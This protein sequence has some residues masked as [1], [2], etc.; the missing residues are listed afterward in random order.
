MPAMGGGTR[1]LLAGG[2]VILLSGVTAAGAGP[3]VPVAQPSLVPLGGA[4]PSDY[5]PGE[6][7]VRFRGGSTSTERAAALR[8]RGARSTDRLG[9]PGLV[10]V[11]LERGASVED[12]A[13]ALEADPDVLYA[14]PNYLNRIS[15]LPDDP[16][17]GRLWGL[18]QPL[19]PDIDAPS[20]WNQTTG[21]SAAV[22]AVIDSGVA[23]GHPDLR[24]NIWMNP[25]ETPGNGVDD[26]GNGFVDDVRG[27]DFV[28]NDATPLDFNG[29]GTHVAGTIGAEGN[30]GIGVTGVNWDVSIM[31]VRAADTFGRLPNSKVVQAIDYACDNGARVVNGSFGSGSFAA[32][33]ASVVTSAACADTL[34]VF[35]AGNSGSDL[36]GTGG[37]QDTYPCE[38]HRPSTG[39]GVNADN[40]L[41]VG[42]SNRT[43]G[44]AG[45]SNRG[46]LAVQLAAPGVSILSTFP[47]FVSVPGSQ[48]G[49]EGRKAAFRDR[50]G[51]R[52]G[53]PP[54][55]RTRA[56]EK[57]G[58]HSLADSP[59][60]RYP[61]N[62]NTS[63]RQLQP[64]SLSGRVGC[65]LEYDMWLESQRHDGVLIDL[66]AGPPIF[67]NL[68]SWA[69]S[70]G[71]RFLP[72]FEDLSDYDG[73]RRVS[74]RF[75]FLSDASGRRDGVYLDNLLVTCLVG[76]ASR[77]RSVSGTSMAAPHVA[78]VA[79]LLL[80]DD[81]ARTVADLEAA[82]LGGVDPVPG[83]AG[84]VETGG[85]LNAARALGVVPD[86]AAPDTTITTGPTGS[87]SLRTATFEFVADEPD[88]TFQCRLGGGSWTTCATPKTYGGLASG[89]H[90]FRVRAMDGNGNGNADPS[91]ATRMW[92][93]T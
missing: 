41:C 78:G 70:T 7:I 69:G 13:A 61:T 54:W 55:D 19:G 23:Y 33:I 2:I 59:R 82:I 22:V 76:N 36:D 42:A 21:S 67:A 73:A 17:L 24:D 25:G 34:F 29:H 88:A 86:Q 39:G 92:R 77:Y 80:A 31:P 74:L 52:T 16:L 89:Q 57:S 18:S 64:F 15:L 6:L 47:R 37:G 87:T 68:T 48:E 51:R 26:D 53:S 35:A 83:M 3:R 72:L 81:P 8:A 10:R 14:E 49:F 66:A 60:G 62:A 32:A 85:R 27:W 20:A 45:F 56:K 38:L 46:A 71:G 93:V 11:E 43:D 44:L 65:G 4:E 90:V 40:V 30:N 28:Q 91:P 5:V 9:L 84:E 50:W 63:I 79:A 1:A 12:A 58:K 75:R